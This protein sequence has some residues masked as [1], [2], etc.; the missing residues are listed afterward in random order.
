VEGALCEPAFVA[1]RNPAVLSADVALAA[2]LL[3]KGLSDRLL[4]VATFRESTRT[5]WSALFFGNKGAGGMGSLPIRIE[6]LVNGH[7]RDGFI[8]AIAT[9]RLA[10]ALALWS[11]T[12][13]NSGDAKALWFRLSTAALHERCPWFFAAAAPDVIA[14]ELYRMA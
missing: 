5:I 13:W 6:S 9:P 3:V 14:A 10:A 11:I 1:A 12:E 7:E 2:I 4:D 8:A